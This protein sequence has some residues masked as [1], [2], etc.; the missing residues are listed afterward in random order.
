[1]P[2]VCVCVCV[3][4]QASRS[5]ATLSC[6][7]SYFCWKNVNLLHCKSFSHFPNK[8]PQHICDVYT[9]NFNENVVNDVINFEQPAPDLVRQCLPIDI[10]GD[11]IVF[12]L[13]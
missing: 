5:R 8:K 4:G 1:M 3:C 11:F 13:I 12:H 2:L 6:D 7:S 9:L 10:L